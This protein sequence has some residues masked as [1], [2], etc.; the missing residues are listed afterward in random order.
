[1]VA[2]AVSIPPQRYL[3]TAMAFQPTGEL[4][5][6]ENDPHHG[7][8]AAGQANQI[9][10]RGRGWPEQAGDTLAIAAGGLGVE[11]GEG[12]GLLGGK[13]DRLAQD[14]TQDRAQ[15]D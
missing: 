9:I 11:R 10:D 5:L 6:Q 14:I 3:G 4:Q 8:G 7:G 1:M 13:L 15:D 2:S 12:L